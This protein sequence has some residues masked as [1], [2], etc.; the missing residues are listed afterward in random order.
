MY[1]TGLPGQYLTSDCLAHWI[2]PLVPPHTPQIQCWIQTLFWFGSGRPPS[3]RVNLESRGRGR[4]R[5]KNQNLKLSIDQ[6]W[7]QGM[8]M[9]RASG[10][11]SKQQQKHGATHCTVPAATKD[12]T[13]T[14]NLTCVFVSVFV[15]LT[16]TL[17][18]VFLPNFNFR[19]FLT[20]VF[21][22]FRLCVTSVFC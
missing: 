6:G 10:P 13:L 7:P 18:F 21:C 4:G 11:R 12:E 20:S 17:T 5:A 19:L 14:F 8:F 15:F 3:R 9:V 22:N 2:L 1:I 16:L